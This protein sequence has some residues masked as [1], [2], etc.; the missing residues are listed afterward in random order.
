MAAE[1]KASPAGLA[2]A[3]GADDGA[4]EVDPG[5]TTGEAPALVEVEHDH[6]VATSPVEP[7]ARG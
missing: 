3:A 1:L 2:T 5:A 6:L 4:A 7:P